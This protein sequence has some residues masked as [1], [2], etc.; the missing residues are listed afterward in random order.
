MRC[1]LSE[2]PKVRSTA[3]AI[4]LATNLKGV[5]SPGE[6]ASVPEFVSCT[7]LHTKST[8]FMWGDL[9]DILV[10]LGISSELIL[11]HARMRCRQ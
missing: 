8:S 1:E 6:K 5:T 4:G 11:R 9:A 7:R 2:L 3:D 10:Y